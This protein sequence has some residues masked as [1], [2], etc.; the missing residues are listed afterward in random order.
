MTEGG[1]SRPKLPTGVGIVGPRWGMRLISDELS[2]EGHASTQRERA[3]EETRTARMTLRKYR[4]PAA[5]AK[6]DRVEEGRCETPAEGL[7][8]ET[9]PNLSVSPEWHS[10]WE[11][12][13][14][15]WH[16]LQISGVP[17]KHPPRSV[18][19]GSSM[20]RCGPTPRSLLRTDFGRF[21]RPRSPT[22]G[23]RK[24]AGLPST[25]VPSGHK[26][27][28]EDSWTHGGLTRLGWS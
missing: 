5:N 26:P 1:S 27:D 4:G 12:N 8:Q 23:R 21:H 17:S 22:D 11:G 9:A 15:P 20:D 18:V 14:G 25:A 3:T 13:P 6:W 10:I 7:A 28:F 16:Q 19:E 2:S 24:A